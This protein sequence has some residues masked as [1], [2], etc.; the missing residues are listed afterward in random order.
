MESVS[1]KLTATD[2]TARTKMVASAPPEID[3][4]QRML[5]RRDLTDVQRKD[6]E[7]RLA[8]V[9]KETAEKRKKLLELAARDYQAMID[10]ADSLNDGSLGITQHRRI[11]RPRARLPGRGPH[12]RRDLDSGHVR[13]RWPPARRTRL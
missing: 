11:R 6:A 10:H 12:D 3:A 1:V 7:Q 8:K 5:A 9:E 4:L 13:R 2:K